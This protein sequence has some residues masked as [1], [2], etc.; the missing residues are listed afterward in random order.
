MFSLCKESVETSTQSLY[1][2]SDAVR[3]SEKDNVLLGGFII[4]S[5]LGGLVVGFESGGREA[6]LGVC[7]SVWRDEGIC[8]VSKPDNRPVSWA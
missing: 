5:V 1:I 3:S 8:R 4:N 2:P 7:I 6:G